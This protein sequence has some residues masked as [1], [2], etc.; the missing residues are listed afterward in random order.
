MPHELFIYLRDRHP[1]THT[2]ESLVAKDERTS[3][4]S[5]LA[6]TVVMLEEWNSRNTGKVLQ[7][8]WR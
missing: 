4:G 3:I 2:E 7:G 5:K 8:A 1:V 6:S